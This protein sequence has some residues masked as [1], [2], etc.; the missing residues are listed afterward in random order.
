MVLTTAVRLVQNG[1]VTTVKR[2]SLNESEAQYQETSKSKTVARNKSANVNRLNNLANDL[3]RLLFQ[4]TNMEIED[5][6]LVGIEYPGRVVNVDN[7]IRTLGG[8]T[9]ISKVV[10]I[11]SIY[12][13][14]S[15]ALLL[16][17]ILFQISLCCLI[18]PF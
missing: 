9:N 10:G 1:A 13:V 11:F 7:M 16:L 18:F 4:K 2:F 14:D 12:L 5:R 17:S 3:I 15:E 6:D 8:L